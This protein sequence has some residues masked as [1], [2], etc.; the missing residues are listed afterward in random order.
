MAGSTKIN[1]TPEAFEQFIGEIEAAYVTMKTPLQISSYDFKSTITASAKM[2]EAIF[3]ANAARTVIADF[4]IKYNDKA[5]AMKKL[6]MDTDAELAQ[7]A[8]KKLSY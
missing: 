2:G 5:Q 8:V 1:Y 4:V 6:A 3:S 7:L